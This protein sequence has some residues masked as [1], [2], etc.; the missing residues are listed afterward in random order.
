MNHEKRSFRALTFIFGIVFFFVMMKGFNSVESY[1]YTYSQ[2]GKEVYV[3]C[4]LDAIVPHTQESAETIR[5]ITEKGNHVEYEEEDTHGRFYA[6][7]TK[8]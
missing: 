3:Y 1:K 6:C 4:E 5:R 2:D 8:P 7:T